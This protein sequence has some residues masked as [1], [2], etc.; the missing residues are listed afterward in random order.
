[1]TTHADFLQFMRDVRDG[2][3]LWP[4]WKR[5]VTINGDYRTQPLR[6]ERDLSDTTALVG[7]RVQERLTLAADLHL[8]AKLKP[9]QWDAVTRITRAVV[10]H[11]TQAVDW[12]VE[13]R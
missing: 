10:L 4:P 6:L 11:L 8:F 3:A 2:I 1:M 7:S 12:Y 13:V 9:R 5:A